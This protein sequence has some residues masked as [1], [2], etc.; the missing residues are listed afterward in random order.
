MAIVLVVIDFKQSYFLLVVASVF[1]IFISRVIVVYLPKFLIP[2]V[3]SF[4]NPEAKLLVRG[5]LRGGLSI[6][7]ALS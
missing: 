6:A 3:F 7:L 1:I 5:G 2:K 4:N